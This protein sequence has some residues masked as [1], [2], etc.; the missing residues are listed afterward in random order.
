M[1]RQKSQERGEASFVLFISTMS[2]ELNLLIRDVELHTG[3]HLDF[4][5]SSLD[6]VEEYVLRHGRSDDQV[7]VR[8]RV[9]RYVGEV[10][11]KALRGRWVLNTRGPRYFGYLLPVISEFSDRDYDVIPHS[12][13]NNLVNGAPRGLLRRV[14]EADRKNCR[15][16]DKL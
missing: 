6:A 14:L 5:D 11:R 15:A 16:C 3:V 8:D 9:A 7:E 10:F 12:L 13:V 1:T 4:S 2:E